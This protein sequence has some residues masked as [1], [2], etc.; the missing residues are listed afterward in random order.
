MERDNATFQMQS[1]ELKVENL[2]QETDPASN[3][4]SLTSNH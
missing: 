3:R 4:K 2:D 1:Q